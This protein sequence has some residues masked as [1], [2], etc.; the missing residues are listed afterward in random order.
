MAFL[1]GITECAADL[2]EAD[3]NPSMQLFEVVSSVVN[4]CAL[5]MNYQ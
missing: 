4:S 3:D 5:I 2:E 1:D